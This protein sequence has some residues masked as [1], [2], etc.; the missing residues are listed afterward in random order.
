M[1]GRNRRY[2]ARLL[3]I[4]PYSLAIGMGLATVGTLASAVPPSPPS[5]TAT[6]QRSATTENAL[7]AELTERGVRLQSGQ[8]VRLPKPLLPDGLDSSQQSEILRKAAGKHPLDRFLRNS[9]VGPFS[10]EIDS[11]QDA[12]GKRDGQRVDFY[13]VAY[14][15]LEKLISDELLGELAGAQESRDKAA[16]PINVRALTDDE[17][18]ARKLVVRADDEL[19]GSY[20]A[21]DVPI[22]DRVQLSGVGV[23]IR[24]K[25]KESVL[26]AWKLDE[27]FADDNKFPNRWR[28]I[29]RDQL[30]KT[31]LG[32]PTPFAG[33]GGYIKV[34]RLH[35][36][37]GA[38]LVE[39]HAAFDEPRGWF[40]GK[41]LLRSKL[42]LVVQENVRTFRRKLAKVSSE[43]Q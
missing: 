23:G 10:L 43:K 25:G 24:Q 32:P 35:E 1:T 30:G 21:I 4:S 18:R 11:V 13:F 34:T 40:D 27:R 36:P 38:L 16:G 41:N 6:P 31:K 3:A 7:L 39:C 29:E 9:V 26:G 2:L 42:P 15:T 14:G 28:P 19:A 22:L 33:L 37:R 5:A 20:V 8:Q 17:L 12:A